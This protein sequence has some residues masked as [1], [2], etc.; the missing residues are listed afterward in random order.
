MKILL[1]LTFFSLLSIANL[2]SQP[3]ASYFLQSNNVRTNFTN[4]A[5]VNFNDRLNAE[6]ANWLA[7][8][9][10]YLK[11]SMIYT[12]QIIL[13]GENAN[14]KLGCSS[15]LY[16]YDYL[17]GPYFSL[18]DAPNTK[19]IAEFNKVW[20]TNKTDILAHKTDFSTD[21]KIDK[22][23]TS[24]YS[25]PGR[26][27]P[28]FES[29][30]Q[31]KIKVANYPLAPF[32]DEDQD[33]IYDPDQ[34]DYPWIDPIN[35]DVPP[36]QLLWT[37]FHSDAPNLIAEFGI[38]S[39]VYYCPENDFLHNTVFHSISVSH[40]DEAFGNLTKAYLGV[41]TDNDLGCYADDYIGCLPQKNMS[42]WYNMDALDGDSIGNCINNIV[43]YKKNIP[44][45]SL[46]FLNRKLDALTPFFNQGIAN[47]PDLI[48]PNKNS[49]EYF[50]VMQGLTRN[51]KQVINP[52]TNQ[53]SSHWFSGNPND[54][55]EWSMR[56]ENLPEIDSRFLS[57]NSINTLE[58]NKTVRLDFAYSFHH[59]KDSNHIQNVN[60]AIQNC[61]KIQSIYDNKFSLVCNENKCQSD[62]V[63]PS[64]TDNNGR[65]EY[66]DAIPIFKGMNL[67]GDTRKDPFI[68]RG[69]SL[70]DWQ[71]KIPNGLNAKYA[72]ANG[73]G[74]INNSD[75]EMLNFYM[76][77]EHDNPITKTYDCNDGDDIILSLDSAFL[78]RSIK[79]IKIR[80]KDPSEKILGFSFEMHIDSSIVRSYS[81][82][83]FKWS[84][85]LVKN[86]QFDYTDGSFGISR[87]QHVMLNDKSTN[88]NFQNNLFFSLAS[89]ANN[90]NPPLEAEV[91]ICNGRFY[92]ADGTSRPLHSNKI[93]VKFTT[94]VNQDD[95]DI[96]N[97]TI[98][99]N[100]ATD[101]L[102]I[103]GIN[104]KYSATLLSIEG[105][106]VR[107]YNQTS[108]QEHFS[109]EGIGAG[110]YFLN[111]EHGGRKIVKKLIVKR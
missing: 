15:Y 105:K 80:F 30:N 50:N 83:Y 77:S 22:K 69:Q 10:P 52:T 19:E 13:C 47:F 49:F 20:A 29:Y 33:G 11:T 64:D 1:P 85:T 97:V 99:P 59:H 26:G 25:W 65:V 16:N 101:R 90:A 104:G 74:I 57:S 81:A 61:D 106:A 44:A 18:K 27:N 21:K 54:K 91:Q 17:P 110:I 38:T 75:L 87:N 95:F 34:G 35:K 56:T 102:Y 12:S 71:T 82:P 40:K 107:K 68:W 46:L 109:L 66:L 3:F 63:W 39:Y 5:I 24:I 14:Q 67:T 96:S 89:K 72:D 98:Y 76:H 70:A 7:P 45:G 103:Q 93:K 41:F 9:N 55:N 58:L 31:F 51:G 84:D 28:H 53:P 60:L 8:N 37:M 79:R 62:C 78:T 111:I 4:Q 48:T 94:I 2:I 100:P 73:D 6:N 23:L 92:F 36:D 86:L 88:E 32:H 43:S 108:S 42:F